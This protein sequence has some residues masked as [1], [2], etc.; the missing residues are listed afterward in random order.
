MLKE[1]YN[2]PYTSHPSSMKFYQDLK[3][4]FRWEGMKKDV[5]KFVNKCFVYRLVKEEH[6]KLVVE[7][8]LL[9]IPKW[10]WEDILM[11]FI[12]GFQEL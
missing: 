11:D 5:P 1:A 3:Q 9:P 4:N 12:V 7:L 6:Q 2:S 10:K 8:Q